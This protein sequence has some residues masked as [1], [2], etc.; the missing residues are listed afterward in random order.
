MMNKMLLRHVQSLHFSFQQAVNLNCPGFKDRC[1]E[2]SVENVCP[3]CN[4]A[5]DMEAEQGI[6]Y[7]DLHSVDQKQ[8]NIISI[9]RCPHCNQGFVVQHK[10]VAQEQDNGV[11][12]VTIKYVETSQS[13]FPA[14]SSYKDIKEDIRKI[15]PKFYDV[16]KQSLIA[17]NSGLNEL[18]GMGFRK[19]IEY[20]VKDFAIS[21]NPNKRSSIE[22][23]SLHSCIENY[24]K[25][26]DARTALLA[27]KWL[28]NNETHYV[29]SNDS[30]D[31]SLL[32][33]LIED[34][35]YYIHREQR[36][37]IAIQ[38]NNNKGQKH[39]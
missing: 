26:S 28:G 3:V 10:M 38:V 11:Y 2:V 15:S 25:N 21:E 7:H 1:F 6:N 19:A 30:D 16:Y 34:T 32:E 35:L 9:H 24:F 39:N 18:Y 29:N 5:I 20:L 37:K 12:G 14:K 23:S 4:Y 22:A 33:N 36:N 8:F 17:K 13:T 31:V 27:C